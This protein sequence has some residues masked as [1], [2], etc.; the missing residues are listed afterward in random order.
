MKVEGPSAQEKDP[1]GNARIG[2]SAN[3]RIKR[4]EFGLVWNA[5]LETGGVLI[6]DNV[7]IELEVSLI[8]V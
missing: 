1:L 2:A 3:T 7:K 8:K 4:S 5:A 6:G